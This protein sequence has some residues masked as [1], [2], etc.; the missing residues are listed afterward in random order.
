M[1]FTSLEYLVFFVAAVAIFFALPHRFRWIFLLAASYFYYMLLDP[2]YGILIGSS[3]LIVYFTALKMQDS[4]AAVK[5][6]L[7]AASLISNLSILFVLKYYN[8]FNNSLKDL[9]HALGMSYNVPEFS[10]LMPIG[11]SFY[12]FQA[13]SYTIDIYRGT[14]PPER[15]LG[16]FALYVSFFPVLLS[17]PI[18]RSTTL[19]PQ[20]YKKVDFD[21]GRVTDGLK[22][23]AW[24]LF[25]KLIIADR[26]S[27][28]VS[29]VYSQP[30][31]VTGLPL[32]VATYFFGIQV[33]CDFSGYTDIAR[34]TAQVMGYDLLPNFRRP[35]FAQS[36]SEYWRRWHMTLISWFRDYLYIPLGGNRV[37]KLR[38][39]FNILIVFTLSGLWHGA[40]WTFVSWGA[41][42]GVFIIVSRMTENLRGLV[43]EKIFS[44][45]AK[46]PSAVYLSLSASL[47]ALGLA[48]RLSGFVSMGAAIAF[49]AGGIAA[50]AVGILKMK[51]EAFA[52]F[53]DNAKKFWM[54]LVTFHL[55][56]F[57]AVFFRSRNLSDA[58]YVITH[59]PGTNFSQ[60]K[61]VFKT[62]EML[63]MTGL[64]LLLLAV[65]VVQERRGSIRQLLKTKPL[66]IRWA[67]YYLF[68]ISIFLGMY[69]TA[70]FIYF[71]F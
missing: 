71:Q 28:Y 46:I 38:W 5:K 53:I 44:G 17:G 30:Q 54:I 27:M 55:F 2:R 29:M 18:E 66:V 39:Y 63:L 40:Q 16:I 56:I 19:L 9:F 33:Y 22:L 43:R 6:L 12:T 20:F 21:Y 4:P 59:F 52:N 58:W 70:Q 42:N 45:I 68:V 10:L 65:H 64:V 48:G 23:M 62:G 7:A 1:L 26:L 31:I 3:T 34:G 69:K 47:I 50:G 25:Q 13:L 61:L 32:L 14:R 67:I 8:F 49:G 15:N 24:G 37:S 60:I 36:I 51:K 11:I 57:G 41:M 35:F